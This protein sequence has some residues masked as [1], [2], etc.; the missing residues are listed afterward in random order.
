MGD[1]MLGRKLH[2]IPVPM[3]VC[4]HEYCIDNFDREA[5]REAISLHKQGQD[6]SQ[7]FIRQKYKKNYNK[8]QFD[9]LF[10]S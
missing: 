4:K 9:K 7:H 10:K 5:E 8:T 3:A 6:N 2:P 1:N